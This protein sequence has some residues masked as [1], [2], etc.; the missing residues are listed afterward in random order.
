MSAPVSLPLPSRFVGLDVHKQSIMATAVDAHQQTVLRPR[1]LALAEFASLRSDLSGANRCRRPASH[2]QRLAA[3]R[4]VAAAV[5]SVT[6]V[7]S[8]VVQLITTARVKTDARDALHLARR[9]RTGLL[10]SIWVP[11]P[12]KSANCAPWWPTDTA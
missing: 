2:N 5:A 12:R 10:T 11:P 9:L 6:V 8:N 1:R 4:F 7:H 3:L